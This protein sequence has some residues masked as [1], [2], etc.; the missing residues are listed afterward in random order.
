MCFFFVVAAK[1]R[2]NVDLPVPAF[3][4]RKSERRVNCMIWSA[5]CISALSES[6]AACCK[7]ADDCS[8]TDKE[9]QR[10]D[11]RKFKDRQD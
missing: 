7:G 6:I 5:C 1:L 10:M 3:P 11:V 9:L 8:K 2:I 4:V